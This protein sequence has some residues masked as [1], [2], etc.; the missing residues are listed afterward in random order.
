MRTVKLALLAAVVATS[1]CD[2][3]FQLEHVPDAPERFD[4]DGGALDTLGWPT[5]GNV[6]P[7]PCSLATFD[8]DGDGRMDDCDNCP[9]DVNTEQLDV[10]RDGIGDTCDLHPT[11]AVERLVYFDGFNV[12]APSSGTAVA[13]TWM[14]DGGLLKQTN[15]N[16][17]RALFAFSGGAWREPI[18]QVRFGNVLRSNTADTFYAGA[19]FFG[20]ALPT[21]VAPSG[22][23]CRVR[24][25]DGDGDLQFLRY[26][27]GAQGVTTSSPMAATADTTSMILRAE[28]DLGELSRCHAI[29]EVKPPPDLTTRLV[30][31]HDATDPAP[32]RFG[33]ATQNARVSFQAIAV[34]ETVYP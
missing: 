29:R 15:T 20:D 12:D 18:L 8:E 28:Q 9:L 3:L 22:T 7:R 2:V 32:V 30:L 16:N 13:G 24:F 31:P 10:D 33:V 4:Y 23:S 21:I 14:V 26:R 19:Y 27:D 25:G 6:E 1:G 17:L 5:N 11:Y 34:Y